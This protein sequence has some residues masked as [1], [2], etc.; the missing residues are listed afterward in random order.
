MTFSS[1]SLLVQNWC[2]L[3]N[4][5]RINL[6]QTIKSKTIASIYNHGNRYR[7]D[8]DDSKIPDGCDDYRRY[9]QTTISRKLAMLPEK[10]KSNNARWALNGVMCANKKARRLKWFLIRMLHA[11]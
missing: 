6:L 1:R 11:K 5:Q 9:L 4:L 8:T 3:R 10:P 2:E 7:A